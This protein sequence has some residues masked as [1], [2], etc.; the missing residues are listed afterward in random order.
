MAYDAAVGG[1]FQII[2][3]S[4][5]NTQGPWQ[6]SSRGAVSPSWSPDGKQVL[7]LGGDATIYSAKV[8]ARREEFLVLNEAPLFRF[9]P[10]GTSLGVTQPFRVAPR[11]ARILVNTFPM[12]PSTPLTVIDPWTSLLARR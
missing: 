7:Y 1:N 9:A 5:P 10:V 12:D 8:D 4:V 6:V 2:V 11:G 3:T